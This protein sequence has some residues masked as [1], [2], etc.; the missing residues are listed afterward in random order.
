MKVRIEFSLRKREMRT[1]FEGLVLRAAEAGRFA[2]A[3]EGETPGTPTPNTEELWQ[4]LVGEEGDLRGQRVLSL[5][6]GLGMSGGD[7][8]T[9]L[10][11]ILR[12]LDQDSSKEG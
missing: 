4:M 12:A 6:Q 11:E 7:V 1:V 8:K 10:I 2:Q 9:L 5:L 3:A